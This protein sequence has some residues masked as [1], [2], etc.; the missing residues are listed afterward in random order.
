MNAE[1]VRIMV[2]ITR[3]YMDNVYKSLCLISCEKPRYDL[4]MVNTA[5]EISRLY[6]LVYFSPSPVGLRKKPID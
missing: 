1:A 3:G 2:G 6:N 5:K 4:D